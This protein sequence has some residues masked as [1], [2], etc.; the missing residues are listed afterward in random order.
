MT[1]R[2]WRSFVVRLVVIVV[3]GSRGVVPVFAQRPDGSPYVPLDHWSRAVIARLAAAGVIDASAATVAWPMQ[4]ARIARLFADADARAKRGD[5]SAVKDL[6]HYA[7]TAFDDELGDAWHARIANG[8]REATGIARGGTSVWIEGTGWHYP[9]PNERANES[10]WFVAPSAGGSITRALAVFAS[11]RVAPER[12]A[13]GEWYGTVALHGV[14]LWLGRRAYSVAGSYG[15]GLVLSDG[16]AFG[17]G[18]VEISDPFHLPGF[19]RSLGELR[20]SAMVAR[21]NR[22]GPDLHPWFAA[23]NVS[24]QPAPSL[25]FGLNRATLFGGSANAVKTTPWTV[26]LMFVGSTDGL[27]KDSDFENQVASI[28]GR[29]QTHIGSLPV[30]WYGEFGV[31]DTGKAFLH[32]P[33]WIAGVDVPSLPMIRK[34]GVGAQRTQLP[35][36]CCGYPPWYQHG[37][38]SDGWTD[39]GVP[40]GVP[41]GGEGS[42]WALRWHYADTQLRV[43]AGG[44]LYTRNRGAENLFAPQRRGRSQGGDVQVLVRASR[45][46]HLLGKLAVERG[47][48]DWSSATTQIGSEVIF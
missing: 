6:A 5:I 20:G 41:L 23:M 46:L 37:A 33:G 16:A 8:W 34:L 40:L 10:A 15:E 35:G 28:S 45:R 9:G 39:R 24:V 32:V 42:E 4:R 11:A 47:A 18:G 26:L 12:I 1:Q 7:R 25:S 13:S 2:F 27:G 19:L 31:D 43:I 29:W 36:S 17:G 48:A 30:A 14:D 21:M 3:C 22:S 44:R 38:L